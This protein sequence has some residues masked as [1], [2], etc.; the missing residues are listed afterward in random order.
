MDS[1]TK[2]FLEQARLQG[3][4]EDVAL[5]FLQQQDG[6][7]S[8]SELPTST[9]DLAGVDESSDPTAQSDEQGFLHSLLNVPARLAATAVSGGRSYVDLPLYGRTRTLVA[10]INE[11][12]DEGVARAQ[13]EGKP[14]IGNAL[15]TGL[16][17]GARGLKEGVG[18]ALEG[19]GMLLGGAELTGGKAALTG[20]G[21][22]SN[23]VR[24]AKSF[25]F[26]SF[27]SSLGSELQTKNDALT[28]VMHIIEGTALGT[29][30]GA[31]VSAVAPAL[32]EKL[33]QTEAIKSLKSGL[34]NLSSGIGGAGLTEGASA[35]VNNI[36]KGIGKVGQGIAK[37]GELATDA[38]E[39]VVGKG[40]ITGTVG[41]PI[42]A[43]GYL[44]RLGNGE[45][46]GAKALTAETEGQIRHGF[47]QPET[48]PEYKKAVDSY[49]GGVNDILNQEYTQGLSKEAQK[50]TEASNTTPGHLMYDLGIKPT[51]DE[52]GRYNFNT[53]ELGSAIGTMADD[54]KT[55]AKDTGATVSKDELR[56]SV[57]R[58]LTAE[59][60]GSGDVASMKKKANDIVEAIWSE[61]DLAPDDGLPLDAVFDARAKQWEKAFSEFEAK[62]SVK[63]DTHRA[64]GDALREDFIT[65][66][67]AKGVEDIETKMNDYQNVTHLKKILSGL[68]GK[69]PSSSYVNRTVTKL[70]GYSV[71]SQAGPL[72]GMASLPVI[73][74]AQKLAQNPG[75]LLRYKLYKVAR[76]KGEKEIPGLTKA[77][78]EQ[79][80]KQLAD[81]ALMR[82]KA[83]VGAPEGVIEANP[84]ESQM[85][86]PALQ[87]ESTIQDETA[88]RDAILKR[89]EKYV[90]LKRA[91][92]ERAIEEIKATGSISGLSPE[93]R[94][95]ITQEVATHVPQQEP[96]D[97][98]QIQTALE[99]LIP[100]I[101]GMGKGTIESFKEE[102]ASTG[103]DTELVDK[104]SR[105]LSKATPTKRR[106]LIEQ[107]IDSLDVAPP[108]GES[109]TFKSGTVP[110]TVARKQLRER[111]IALEIQREA[112]E[113]NPLN[114]LVRFESKSRPGELP[115]IN[116]GGKSKFSKK[117]DIIIDEV[118]GNGSYGDNDQND[119]AIKFEEFL[120]RKREFQAEEKQ[121]KEDIKAYKK[122]SR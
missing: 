33:G 28:A 69:K 61:H 62:D 112:I 30:F 87:I 115:E 42:D 84:I 64:I 98:T 88:Q 18:T 94:Q 80:D 54:I 40:T 86:D 29:L 50:L 82:T 34:G 103:L 101:E 55:V 100:A 117:G 70:I 116:S 53:K 6:S 113:N 21:A 3:V 51:L 57:Y 114:R 99:E 68:E 24:G 73:D 12:V 11:A 25:V 48:S 14:T 79:I 83:P 27:A 47:T 118:V 4:P 71:L 36:G 89:L 105:W 90:G 32:G 23:A 35:L 93:T 65:Q 58:K 74:A 120:K 9:S 5:S 119:I 49:A 20:A 46:V 122:G 26:P 45:S 66:M 59:H 13:A 111:T 10:P 81:R 110:K 104:Y 72:A 31:G 121:L 19:A 2:Q 56:S 109:S 97:P 76:A 22:F 16:T 37:V 67:K 39:K 15:R 43:L 92:A 91:T 17:A 95:A 75:L 102:L 108:I 96:K 44:G 60:T 107:L 1:R 52:G 7:N 38:A 8:P 85:S 78:T 77:F 106:P 41:A 63:G